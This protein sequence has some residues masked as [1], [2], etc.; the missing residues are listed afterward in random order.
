[1]RYSECTLGR[2]FVI[3]LEDGDRLPDTIE[4]LA[5]EKDISRGMCFVV[6]GIKGGGKVVVG[7]EDVDASPVNPMIEELSGVHEIAGVGMVFPDAEGVPKL[8]MHAAL[9]RAG[10][11]IAGCIRPGIETWTVGEVVLVELNGSGAHRMKHPELGFELLE[12]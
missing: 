5:G 12:P 8:H 11:T 10:K 6:G 9:G 1:M 2:V 4:H 3:R 7:P